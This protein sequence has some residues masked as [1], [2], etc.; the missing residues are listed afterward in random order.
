MVC[1]AIWAS[2]H[3]V[4]FVSVLWNDFIGYSNTDYY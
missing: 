2:R 1:K 3:G 4:G